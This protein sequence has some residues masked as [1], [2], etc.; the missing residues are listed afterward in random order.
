MRI[1]MKYFPQAVVCIALFLTAC[2]TTHEPAY[3]VGDPVEAA[4][5]NVRLAVAY[6]HRREYEV[7]MAKLQ[8]A[9][10]QDPKN[11]DAHTTLGV[12]YET[13]GERKKAG[14][15]YR[16]AVHLAPDDPNAHNNYGTWLCQ[17]GRLKQAQKEF[18]KAAESPFYKTPQVAL[19]NAGSCAM[20]DGEVA[21]AEQYF[22][23]ALAVDEAYPDALYQMASLKYQQ[24]DYMSARAF[25]QRY[26][27][28]ARANAE[29]LALAIRI[30]NAL[31]VD[32][33]AWE[34]TSELI[35]DFPDS[36]QA[37]AIYDA[38]KYGD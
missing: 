11:A 2:V 13:L 29:S 7:A 30:E 1:V 19:T 20:R 37:R 33:A 28:I 23:R 21:R 18:T 6:M 14:T 17:D 22:R 12:L 8:R 26:L 27:S 3:P 4:R 25:V 16:E 5:A 34:Y 36:P 9:L 32:D 35:A 24:G 15:H 31:G 10:E 38:Y